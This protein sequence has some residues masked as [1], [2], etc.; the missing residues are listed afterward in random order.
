MR[1]AERV[2]VMDMQ[3]EAVIGMDTL[4]RWS[5][6]VNTQRWQLEV[7]DRAFLGAGRPA[8]QVHLV[9]E[10]DTEGGKSLEAGDQIF[11]F[12]FST[13][14]VQLYIPGLPLRSCW[15]TG[16]PSVQGAIPM[17]N[18]RFWLQQD[19]NPRPCHYNADVLPLCYVDPST[20]ELEER[21]TLEE[22]GRGMVVE[23]IL[24]TAS[25]SCAK[26]PDVATG[27]RQGFPK[28]EEIP[29]G[30][31][32]HGMVVKSILAPSSACG[33]EASGRIQLPSCQVPTVVE[34]HAKSEVADDTESCVATLSRDFQSSRAGGGTATRGSGRG[35]RTFTMDPRGIRQ[36]PGADW[37]KDRAGLRVG[38]TGVSCPGGYK[39]RPWGSVSVQWDKNR[40]RDSDRWCGHPW[41]QSNGPRWRNFWG[42][43]GVLDSRN[44]D[45]YA[46]GGHCI[47][48]TEGVKHATPDAGSIPVW[49][50]R[51]RRDGRGHP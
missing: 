26:D 27:A 32:G 38:R 10:D 14:R 25:A 35:I 51:H 22:E 11:C 17:S 40:R 21:Q 44:F 4:Y 8:Q 9:W 36:V 20:W 19:S 16:A 33:A 41:S 49:T 2:M 12:C 50:R 13:G 39:L 47:R 6:I 30:T 42:G 7:E 45:S 43:G 37:A 28:L 3:P 18:F 5:A 34:G 15:T 29:E 24:A 1:V 31:G 23:S 46:G 48:A